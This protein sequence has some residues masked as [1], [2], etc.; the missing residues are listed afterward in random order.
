L[1]TLNYFAS[2]QVSDTRDD[3]SSN[4]A[5]F[6]TS[7]FL[8]RKDAKNAGVSKALSLFSLQ[9]KKMND[10]RIS[11]PAASIPI[12]TNFISSSANV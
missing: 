11:S 8:K 7:K 4:A 10:E 9:K 1:E 5:G 6:T 2:V 3:D 12:T